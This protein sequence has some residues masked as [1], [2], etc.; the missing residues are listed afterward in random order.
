MY[1]RRMGHSSNGIGNWLNGHSQRA[2]VSGSTFSDTDSEIPCALSKFADDA[3]L[4]GVADTTEGQDTIQGH[5]DKL[6]KWANGNLMK[7]NKSLVGHL[8]VQQVQLDQ[9]N[10]KQ[11]QRLGEEHTGSSSAEKDLGAL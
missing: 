1:I 9:H 7:F 3:K 4:R 5:L 8:E 11:E 10:P 2:L 6:E